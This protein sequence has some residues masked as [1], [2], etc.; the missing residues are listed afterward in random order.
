MPSQCHQSSLGECCTALV[1]S[2]CWI[3][4]L[5]VVLKSAIVPWH[6]KCSSNCVITDR[7][8]A[9]ITNISARTPLAIACIYCASAHGDRCCLLHTPCTDCGSVRAGRCWLFHTPC[10]YIARIAFPPERAR[11]ERLEEAR[12]RA[13]ATQLGET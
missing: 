12:A 3:V 6:A 1:P 10:T 13:S 8:R 4:Y 5:P 2:L 9:T 7:S 11:E